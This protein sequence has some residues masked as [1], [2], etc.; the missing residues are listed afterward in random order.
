MNPLLFLAE[1]LVRPVRSIFTG[2]GITLRHLA[3]PAEVVTMQYPD[4]RWE[5][6]PRWRG[7]H[8]VAFEGAEACIGCL[9][10]ERVCSERAIRIRTSVGENKKRRVDAFFVHLGLCS[11]CGHCQEVCPVKAI[12]MGPGYEASTARLGDL[13]LDKERLRRAPVFKEPAPPAAGAAA[14]PPEGGEGK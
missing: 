10:C 2:L 8:S 12:R 1:G 4:E 7:F 6:P 3:D 5:V 11:Y 9:M 13:V 14:K